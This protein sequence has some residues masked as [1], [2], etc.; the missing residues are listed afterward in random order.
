MVLARFD[1]FAARVAHL[2][3]LSA[4]SLAV[5]ILQPDGG[6]ALQTCGCR[7][8]VRVSR[9][10]GRTASPAVGISRAGVARYRPAGVPTWVRVTDL[11]VSRLGVAPIAAD[12]LSR[13]LDSR[14][15]SIQKIRVL[16]AHSWDGHP[17]E[18]L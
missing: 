10:R 2:W 1:E 12:L 6:L 14:S 9:L 5:G 16:T 8:G 13:L 11:R 7:L 3:S 15:P 17:L 4:G 18:R